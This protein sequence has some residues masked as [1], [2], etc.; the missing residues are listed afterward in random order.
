[1]KETRLAALGSQ[2]SL[3][4]TSQPSIKMERAL[5]P[6]CVCNGAGVGTRWNVCSSV[7]KNSSEV[8]NM[9]V[10]FISLSPCS[11]ALYYLSSTD[12]LQSGPAS[13][14]MSGAL[15]ETQSGPHWALFWVERFDRQPRYI[16]EPSH[17]HYRGSTSERFWVSCGSAFH[18]LPHYFKDGCPGTKH[19]HL[20]LLFSDRC[21]EQV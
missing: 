1:M 11:P 13:A 16:R 14:N 10:G 6:W 20:W 7:S 4:H 15:K 18:S 21:R 12:A 5:C 8:L 19:H 2:A 17:P 3:R 9:S